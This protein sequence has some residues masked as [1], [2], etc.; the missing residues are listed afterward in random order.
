MPSNFRNLCNGESHICCREEYFIVALLPP[1]STLTYTI[2]HPLLPTICPT[3]F[4]S[5]P[6]FLLPNNSSHLPHYRMDALKCF[7][8]QDRI[9]SVL[10]P[11]ALGPHDSAAERL[12]EA[13]EFLLV[14]IP[15]SITL[16]LLCR[17][18][19]VLNHWE[20]PTSAGESRGSLSAQPGPE[21]PGT[22]APEVQAAQV[23]E[24]FSRSS[25]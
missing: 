13:V 2:I 18:C 24:R 23:M 8:V 21:T 19:S 9:L 1:S 16:Q 7:R 17:P 12:R 5:I 4:I 20:S 14:L 22:S 3:G 11:V 15:V 6:V 25:S 10:Q